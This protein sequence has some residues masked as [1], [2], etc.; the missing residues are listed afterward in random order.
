VERP[1]TQQ[2]GVQV[3][4]CVLRA[5][6]EPVRDEGGCAEWPRG[7]SQPALAKQSQSEAQHREMGEAR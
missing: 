7:K 1:G 2:G 6:A 3:S 5:A 4:A